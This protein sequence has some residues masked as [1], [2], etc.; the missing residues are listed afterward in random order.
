MGKTI[1]GG[2]CSPFFCSNRPN[3]SNGAN[4]SNGTG[5]TGAAGA[6]GPKGVTG[7]DTVVSLEVCYLRT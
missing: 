4:R 2:A 3:G 7:T 5:P 6:T 1:E